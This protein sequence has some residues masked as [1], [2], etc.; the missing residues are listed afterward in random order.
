MS[1]RSRFGVE[2][3]QHIH[4]MEGTSTY[5]IWRGLKARCLN[6]KNKDYKR[7]GARGISIC[8]RWNYFKFFLEDMGIRPDGLQ[9]DRI[10]NNGNYC[11]E[12]CRWVTAK[13]NSAN[14]RSSRNINYNGQTKSIAD[15]AKDLGYTR[16]GMRYR[17]NHLSV[18]EAMTKPKG[19]K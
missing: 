19:E 3:N 11:K 16:Q 4:G 5:A 10:D 13:E 12:N 8:E 15:W 6:P 1:K 2:N 7:Y 14:R 18:E 9:I 17:L